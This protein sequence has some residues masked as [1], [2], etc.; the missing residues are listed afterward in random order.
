[1]LTIIS[2]GQILSGGNRHH[3][4]YGSSNCL[5][6]GKADVEEPAFDRPLT[7]TGSSTAIVSPTLYTHDSRKTCGLPSVCDPPRVA[8]ALLTPYGRPEVGL[9]YGSMPPNSD[10][11]R[12][13]PQ[14]YPEEHIR[15][16]KRGSQ[17][18]D[19]I[20][21]GVARMPSCTDVDP[22]ALLFDGENHLTLQSVHLAVIASEGSG[23]MASVIVTAAA[24][25]F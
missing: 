1:M 7:G 5:V 11:L 25:P 14:S 3:D 20:D 18:R 23:R 2:A 6:P 16:M 19:R 9:G 13:R 4:F 10:R 8:R 12:A 17:S 24:T 21:P 22:A 15:Q